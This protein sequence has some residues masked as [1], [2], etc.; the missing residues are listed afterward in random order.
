MSDVDTLLDE[1]HMTRFFVKLTSQRVFCH[2]VCLEN[3]HYYYLPLVGVVE[4]DRLYDLLLLMLQEDRP[5]F[6]GHS[7]LDAYKVSCYN[8]LMKDHLHRNIAARIM[9]V[10]ADVTETGERAVLFLLRAT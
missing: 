8:I 5:T 10:L 4:D 2:S 6:S 9:K 3:L 7:E 1:E